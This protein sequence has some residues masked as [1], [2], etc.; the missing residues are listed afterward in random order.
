MMQLT[1]DY[2]HI[3][4]AKRFKPFSLKFWPHNIVV[5]DNS[6]FFTLRLS[7]PSIE[8]KSSAG[9]L[10]V[11]QGPDLH[12]LMESKSKMVVRPPQ[13][14]LKLTRSFSPLH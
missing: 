9:K 4:Q 5:V 11:R 8:I 14:E 10:D 1:I 2:Q 6:W 12:L 13:L 7:P 3:P